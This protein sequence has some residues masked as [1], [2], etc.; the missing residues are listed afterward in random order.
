MEYLDL[1]LVK[2]SRRTESALCAISGKKLGRESVLTALVPEKP[3]AQA[4]G[5]INVDQKVGE[6]P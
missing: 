1:S 4:V 2:E 6:N 3:V 5:S